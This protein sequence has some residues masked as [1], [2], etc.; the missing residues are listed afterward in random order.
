MPRIRP[1]R[2]AGVA[3]PARRVDVASLL[4]FLPPS[5]AAPIQARV[6]AL[7]DDLFDIALDPAGPAT[8]ARGGTVPFA[9]T[10]SASSGRTSR[11]PATS[12]SS[13]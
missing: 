5:V 3:P 8:C 2:F 1:R 4:P 11:R 13:R 10:S 12:A 9:S 7:L 6:N